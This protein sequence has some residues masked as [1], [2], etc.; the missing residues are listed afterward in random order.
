MGAP[1]VWPTGW[2][3]S[4]FRTQG[5]FRTTKYGD[6]SGNTIHSANFHDGVRRICDE[7]QKMSVSHE[8]FTI[9]TDFHVENGKILSPESAEQ[10]DPGVAVYWLTSG[11]EK[12]IAIDRYTT[13]ADNLCAIAATLSA[14]RTISRHGG[15][16]VLDRTFVGLLTEPDT[17]SCFDILGVDEH[18]SREEIESAYR[19]LAMRHHPD[20]GG[21]S[22]DMQ[23]INAAREEA[24]ATLDE[25]DN[26]SGEDAYE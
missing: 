14:F 3:R 19:R 6:W 12:C 23:R 11:G 15:S 18:A 5:N 21:T 13:W 4:P 8:R 7:F 24:L 16:E 17:E 9:T 25:E 2:P 26:V 1:L 22:K 10:D 20:R